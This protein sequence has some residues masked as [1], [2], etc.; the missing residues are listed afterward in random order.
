MPGQI[1]LVDD[2][3]QI[4]LS[5][6]EA[7][8]D[9]GFNVELAES[10]EDALSKIASSKP[11]VVLSDIRMPGMDGLELLKLLRERVPDVDVVLMTAFDDMPTVVSA[12]REGAFDF[13]VKPVNLDELEEVLKRALEDKRTRE[14]A[15]LEVEDQAKSYQGDQDYQ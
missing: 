14:R 15:R 11:Q 5:L 8:D 7:L 6:S 3:A 10:A 2:D 13:L 9:F 1:L 4:R 12:M